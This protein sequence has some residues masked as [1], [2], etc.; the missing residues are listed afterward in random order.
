MRTL[1]NVMTARQLAISAGP[2]TTNLAPKPLE[3]L[4]VMRVIKY[5]H[6]PTWPLCMLT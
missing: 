5:V 2:P 1:E 6:I 3:S 4:G